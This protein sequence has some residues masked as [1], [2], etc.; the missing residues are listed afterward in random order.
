VLQTEDGNVAVD[1][2]SQ[3][4]EDIR[5]IILDADLP[6]RSGLDCLRAIRTTRGAVPVIILTGQLV[7]DDAQLDEHTITIPEPFEISELVKEVGDALVT[8]RQKEISS[9][10]D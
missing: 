10:Q 6:G 3:R 5:L 8:S 7:P 2:F 1:T 4:Q 9:G